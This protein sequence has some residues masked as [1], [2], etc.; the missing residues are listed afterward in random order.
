MKRIQG[1]VTEPWAVT[2]KARTNSFRRLQPQSVPRDFLDLLA[3]IR[4][5]KVTAL[6]P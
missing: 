6:G 5:R 3:G 2:D 4:Q 1:D